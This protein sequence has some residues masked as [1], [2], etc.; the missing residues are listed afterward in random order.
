ML[1]KLIE[2]LFLPSYVE[3]SSMREKD[4]FVAARPVLRL[5]E[6]SG[7]NENHL[8]YKVLWKLQG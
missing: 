5:V 3:F 2:N 8:Y 1:M 6:R 7:E 4:E